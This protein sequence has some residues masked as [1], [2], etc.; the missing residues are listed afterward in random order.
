MPKKRTSI[1]T[2]SSVSTETPDTPA[3]P[4][5]PLI[6]QHPFIVDVLFPRHELHIIGGPAHAG[7]TMLLFH[8]MENWSQSLNVFGYPSHPAKFCYV[9]CNHSLSA[10]QEA[11]KCAGIS[12]SVPMVSLVDVACKKNF[13]SVHDLAYS[14]VKDV[15]VIFLDG[16]LYIAGSSGLDNAIVGE[17]LSGMIREMKQREITVVATGRCAKPKDNRS[18]VRSIDRFL[19]AT[20]WTELS[21]TFIAIEP[22]MPNQ[23]RNDR[24]VV[25]VMPKRAPTFTLAYRFSGEGKL[26]EVSDEAGAD[27]PERLDEIANIVD[28]RGPGQRIATAELLEIGRELGVIARSSMMNYV[29]VL[30]RQGRLQDGGHGWYMTPSVQ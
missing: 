5:T 2:K 13:D 21:S 30:V 26:S 22:K 15:E 18:S 25:T 11:A 1:K 6:R 28:A 29:S 3:A 9:S 8:I 7:K 17:F 24:R 27:S 4:A 20:A 19:G 16:I 23:P 12:A 14:A 10:C